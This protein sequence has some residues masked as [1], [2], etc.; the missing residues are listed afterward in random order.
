[1]KEVNYMTLLH[2]LTFLMLIDIIR[3]LFKGGKDNE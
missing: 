2:L 1:M 3:I